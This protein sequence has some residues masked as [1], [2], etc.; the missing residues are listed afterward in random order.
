MKRV[1]VA[2]FQMHTLMSMVLP[3]PLHNLNT[4]NFHELFAQQKL[5]NGRQPFSHPLP[6]CLA[7][8]LPHG[9]HFIALYTQDCRTN[10]LSV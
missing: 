3:P 7:A 5:Y 6:P 8:T 1:V 4:G 10:C 2:V 9:F